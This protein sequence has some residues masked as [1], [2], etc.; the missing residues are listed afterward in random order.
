MDTQPLLSDA[1]CDRTVA[2][3]PD[4]YPS[5]EGPGV[6]AMAPAEWMG[7]SPTH[8]VPAT[9]LGEGKLVPPP[10]DLVNYPD[11]NPVPSQTHWNIPSISE[12]VAREAL[13]EYVN[14][15][16]CYSSTPAKEMVF[17]EL[18]PLNTYRY[19]LETFTESRST[20]WAQEPYTG[21]IVDGPAFGPSPPIW[22]IEVPVPPMFQDTVKKVPVPHTAL[23]QGCTNCSALGKIACSKCT[24]TGRIQC[25]VCNGRG[26][27]I[28]D[29]RCSRCSGNGLSRCDNCSG[30]G[31]KCCK[32]C[33][34]R[35]QI[36]C[37]TQ[38]TVTWKTN[39]FEYIGDNHVGFPLEKL[40]VVTGQKVFSDE[41][42]QVCPVLGFP[43][44][45]ISAASQKGISDHMAQFATTCRI[46]KQRHTIEWIPVTQAHYEWDG[47]PY[48]YFIYGNE[49]IVY[50]EDYPG[51]C[52]CCCTII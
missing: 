33:S 13:K 20:D 45:A 28:G 49:N 4:F 22:Y 44:P 23:V 10:A 21:Q 50:T 12:D 42:F 16:C 17:S 25:W 38:L 39:V 18:T 46:F 2:T 24:A 35:G 19:R 27:T 52:C 40:S 11:R 47:K 1:D 6:D 26:F 15:K 29:Q 3:A 43:E 14:N 48:S 7:E 9:A 34:G 36:L 37:Y 32:I 8:S 5:P 41:Q 51:G 30:Q 31:S